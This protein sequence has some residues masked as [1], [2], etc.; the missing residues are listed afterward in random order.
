MDEKEIYYKLFN[1]Q[2]QLMLVSPIKKNIVEKLEE[3][4][5]EKID[6]AN[7]QLNSR[8]PRFYE[9]YRIELVKL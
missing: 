2:N 9:G 1:F 3:C 4:L 8:T 5:D 7:L 6:N